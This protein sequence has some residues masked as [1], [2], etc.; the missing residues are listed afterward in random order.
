M[1]KSSGKR[2]RNE[3]DDYP[4]IMTLDDY[5]HY[6]GISKV[7]GRRWIAEGRATRL[8]GHRHIRLLRESIRIYE[9][10]LLKGPLN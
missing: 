3:L 2:N 5:C 6:Y 1:A 7:T 4:A 8:P 9:E 10:S